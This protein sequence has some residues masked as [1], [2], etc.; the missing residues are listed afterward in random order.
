MFVVHVYHGR[1]GV[2]MCESSGERRGIE[3][4][5]HN[6]SNSPGKCRENIWIFC[7]GCPDFIIGLARMKQLVLN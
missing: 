6:Q 2:P 3:E 1:K 5:R 7:K 4:Q